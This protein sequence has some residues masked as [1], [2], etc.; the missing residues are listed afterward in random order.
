MSCADYSNKHTGVKEGVCWGGG[1]CSSSTV[2]R[3]M[4]RRQPLSLECS[5]SF[6][7]EGRRTPPLLR[8]WPPYSVLL[9]GRRPP[10]ALHSSKDGGWE[11]GTARSAPPPQRNPHSDLISETYSSDPIPGSSA[12]IQ[13]SLCRICWRFVQVRYFFCLVFWI[14]GENF[15]NAYLLFLMPYGAIKTVAFWRFFRFFVFHHVR[16]SFSQ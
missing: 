7:A 9:N 2:V 12:Q 13:P 6:S 11:G 5:A 1:A 10:G 16:I 3:R 8:R 4:G 14:F 15:D